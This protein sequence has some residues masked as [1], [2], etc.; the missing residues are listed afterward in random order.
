MTTLK[1]ILFMFLAVALS[2]MVGCKSMPE[3]NPA[4]VV[5]YATIAVDPILLEKEELPAPPEKKIF[6]QKTPSEQRSL[7][8]TYSLTLQTTIETLNLK[9]KEVSKVITT[10]NQRVLN[11]NAEKGTP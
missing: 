11:L 5:I 1:Y 6:L 4:P 10:H 9:L 2:S 8:A 3:I 7:L